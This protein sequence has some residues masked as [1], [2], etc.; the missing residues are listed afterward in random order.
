MNCNAVYNNE[1]KSAVKLAYDIKHLNDVI[2][3]DTTTT[4]YNNL[5]II[6]MAIVH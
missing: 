5:V 6:L 2:T 3:S 1:I 4:F